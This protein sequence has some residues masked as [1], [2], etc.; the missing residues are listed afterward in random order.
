MKN[1]NIRNGKEKDKLRLKEKVKRGRKRMNERAKDTIKILV[2]MKKKKK[3]KGSLY[4]LW[5]TSTVQ[6]TLVASFA[7]DNTAITL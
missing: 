6:E 4:S 3:K 7:R 5:M 1:E 2:T